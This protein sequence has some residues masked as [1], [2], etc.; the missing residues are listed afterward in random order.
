MKALPFFILVLL[1]TVSRGHTQTLSG[2]EI[3]AGNC[4]ACHS[5]GGGDIVGPDLAGVTEK[6]EEDWLKAFIT[7]S[8]NLIAEGDKDAVEVF[9]KYNK[10]IMPAHNFNEE[11]LGSLLGYIPEAGQEASASSKQAEEKLEENPDKDVIPAQATGE[12][13]GWLVITLLATL[14][15]A[16]TIL[17][18]IAT[19]LYR[20]L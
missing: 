2:K 1:F 10:I 12:G 16:A 19:A 7:N 6:R 14:G 3:F 5:I 17:V 8:Q 15:V 4:K 20:M 18:I 9:N 13:L 11:E